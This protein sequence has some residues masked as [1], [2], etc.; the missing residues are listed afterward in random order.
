MPNSNEDLT[1]KYMLELNNIN[2]T[3]M[4]RECSKSTI[5]TIEGRHAS[6]NNMTDNK[7]SY[8]HTNVKKCHSDSNIFISCLR[9]QNLYLG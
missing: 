1:N 6:I 4:S 2:I 8:L 5:K 9:R 7:N 3:N